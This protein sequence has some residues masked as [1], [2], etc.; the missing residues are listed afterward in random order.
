MN[1]YHSLCVFCDSV[2]AQWVNYSDEKKKPTATHSIERGFLS[3]IVPEVSVI[4]RVIFFYIYEFLNFL[5]S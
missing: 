5:F 3:Q 4:P 1:G 2:T